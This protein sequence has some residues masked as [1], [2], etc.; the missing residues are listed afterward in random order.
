MPA[1]PAAPCQRDEGQRD[2]A[3]GQRDEGRAADRVPM[4][5]AYT[6]ARPPPSSS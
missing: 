1:A 2:E 4:P 3:P 5:G 6:G